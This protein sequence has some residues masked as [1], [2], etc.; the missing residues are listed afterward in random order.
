MIRVKTI[1]VGELSIHI[2]MKLQVNMIRALIMKRYL[3]HQLRKHI[4]NQEQNKEQAQY[5]AYQGHTKDINHE[6][7][8]N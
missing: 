1:K 8:T 4:F 5:E 3:K 7:E 6:E 2:P